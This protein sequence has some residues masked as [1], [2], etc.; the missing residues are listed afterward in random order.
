MTASASSSAE[1]R[2]RRA[3]SAF[4]ESVTSSTVSSPLPSG[5]GTPANSSVRP[6]ASVDLPAALLAV[7]RCRAHHFA[8][9]LALPRPGELRGDLLKQRFDPRM[10]VEELLRQAPDVGE[11]AVPQ[12]HPAVRREHRERFEQAVEGRGAGAQQRVAHRRKRQLL[13]PVLG[14]QHQPA[15]GHRLGDDRASACRRS[16]VQASSCG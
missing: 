14:D 11:A 9:R 7:E 10:L 8:D 16:S 13:G 12:L 3:S 6:S 4:F 2:S 15:V 5:S 1:A